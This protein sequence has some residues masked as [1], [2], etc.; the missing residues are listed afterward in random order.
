[1]CNLGFGFRREVGAAKDGDKG[2]VVAGAVFV[3]ERSGCLDGGSDGV[4]G[5]GGEGSQLES[6]EGVWAGDVGVFYCVCCHC[7]FA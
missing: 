5:G 6:C 1:M 7:L 3:E 2:V 4:V